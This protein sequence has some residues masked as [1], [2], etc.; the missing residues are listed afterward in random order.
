MT[1]FELYNA[2]GEL[3]NTHM[4]LF[5]LYNALDKLLNMEPRADPNLPVYLEGCDC[6]NE[7]ASVEYPTKYWYIPSP[8]AGLR[9]GVFW[10]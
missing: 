1:L 4:T 2:L 9:R 6:V 3:L 10:V 7:S 8:R 5:E